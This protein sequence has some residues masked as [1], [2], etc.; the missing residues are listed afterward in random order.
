MRI[1]YVENQRIFA[2]NVIRQFLSEHAVTIVASLNGAREEL[3]KAEFDLLL[4]DYDLD[5]GKGDALLRELRVSG[6]ATTAIGVSSHKEGNAAL[7][8]AGASAVCSKMEFDNI[9]S[10][11]DAI[12]RPKKPAE[13]NLLWWVIPAA[14]AG[15]PMPW[16][17]PDRRFNGGGPLNAYE[18]ELSSLYAAGIRAVVCL[19]NIP[20][21]AKVYDSAGF[22]FQ[23]LPVPD[24]GA[25]TAE[26]AAEFAAFVD[27]KLHEGKPVAVHCEAGLGRTGTMI[28]SYLIWKGSTAESAINQVRAVERSAVETLRQIRFLEEWA[29][30]C[31]TTG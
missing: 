25:P 23:C 31:R 6:K 10:V 13:T 18:D 5:D 16:I 14:L 1:L 24:G 17:H 8:K 30:T 27:Q 3:Q 7:L 19:L 9:R 4:V 26:Q 11:I 15:M 29:A 28:A 22:A 2:E 20:S 12:L 21:D